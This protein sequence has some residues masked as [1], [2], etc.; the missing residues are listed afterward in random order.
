MSGLA[1]KAFFKIMDLWEVK[2]REQRV[3][4]GDIPESTYHKW[5]KFLTG[6]L[7]KDQLDRIS[8]ILGIYKALQILIPDN[9]QSDKWI[10]QANFAP[11]FGG[12]PPIE[13]MLAGTMHDL[14]VVRQYLDAQRGA[15]A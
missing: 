10:K 1:L 11:L 6:N 8:Y 12:N 7:T 14:H 4:L 15:W 3:L 9:H 13:R 5:K 2:A